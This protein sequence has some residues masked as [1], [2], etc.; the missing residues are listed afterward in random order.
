M[1]KLW[2]SEFLA[3]V[4]CLIVMALAVSGPSAAQDPGAP[5]FN[6]LTWQI[7]HGRTGQNL[8]EGV[9]TS[10]TVSSTGGKN[11]GQLCHA[12]LDGQVYA[13]PLVVTNVT[14]NAN[15]R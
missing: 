3:S 1:R 6:V 15:G 5:S 11:F 4:V 8:R 9:L 13:Q 14:I 2:T 12:N 10:S 7:D